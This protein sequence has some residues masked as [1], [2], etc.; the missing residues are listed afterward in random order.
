MSQIAV[1]DSIAAAALGGDTT[2]LGEVQ[3][4]HAA[5]QA[6]QAKANA[7][8]QPEIAQVLADGLARSEAT[9]GEAATMTILQDGRVVVQIGDDEETASPATPTPTPD[10]AKATTA[11][12]T[13]NGSKHP[14]IGELRTR[15][16]ACGADISEFASQNKKGILAAIEAAEAAG[17]EAEP[18]VEPDAAVESVTPPE[19]TPD[20]EPEVEAE[21]EAEDDGLGLDDT[22]DE[23][24]VESPANEEGAAPVAPPADDELDVDSWLDD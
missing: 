8:F 23:E 2:V 20:P 18:V 12:K 19:G 7:A 24:P 11:P 17:A 3:T 22:P 1:P 6:A 16:A 5:L 13:S 21:P 10:P 9:N 15:A 4:A 14:S